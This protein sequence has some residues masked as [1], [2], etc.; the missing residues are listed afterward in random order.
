MIMAMTRLPEV[1]LYTDGGCRPNPGPG[2]WGAVLIL[3]DG[4][5]R[6][7]SGGAEEATNNRMEITAAVEGLRALD[8][9]HRVV[10]YT[11]S[12]YLRRGVTEWLPRWRANGWRTSGKQ[13]VKNQDLW[14]TL[15]GELQRHRVTWHWVKGHAGDRWNE[16]ADRLATAAIP[17]AAAPVDDPGAVHLFTAAAYSG[18]RRAGSWGVLLRFGDQEKLLAER[19]EDTS[20]NRMHIAAAVA[21]LGRLKRPVRAHVYTASDYLR[22]GATAWLAGW[23]S[24]GWQ[25]RDGRPVAHSDLWRRLDGL[26]R[27]HDVLWH[28]VSRDRLPEEMERA[29]EA[30]REA[31]GKPESE[32][33]SEPESVPGT[34]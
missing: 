1:R 7:L 14:R 8:S 2:G 27:R 11:D 15:D 21:G 9:P 25:T 10:L 5:H 12:E 30:A 23:R 28:V 32:R 16:R 26:L 17:S 4:S 6:E 18:K 29:K 24:R 34:P 13:A 3:D 31:L 33:E 19:V 20:A 22:D